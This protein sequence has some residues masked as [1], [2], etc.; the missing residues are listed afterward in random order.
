[1]INILFHISYLIL[2]S[3]FLYGGFYAAKYKES[4]FS[5]NY[6]WLLVDFIGIGIIALYFLI[7]HISEE[8]EDEIDIN[9]IVFVMIPILTILGLIESFLLPRIHE[10]FTYDWHR[11]VSWP[12]LNFFTGL[13]I[14]G[15]LIHEW[16]FD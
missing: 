5:S 2:G 6:D 10:I 8:M 7:V 14:L 1:M 4:I 15:G 13:G 3:I 12:K 11:L 9:P 16:F